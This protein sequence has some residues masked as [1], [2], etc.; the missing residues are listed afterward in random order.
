MKLKPY[1]NAKKK[2]KKKLCRFGTQK[3]IQEFLKYICFKL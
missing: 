2:K 3:Y 1:L